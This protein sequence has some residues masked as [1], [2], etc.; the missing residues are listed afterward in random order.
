MRRAHSSAR[1]FHYHIM[2]KLKTIKGAIFDLDGTLLDSLGA[3]SEIDRKFFAKR[4]IPL[5]PDYSQA[6]KHLYL[7]EAAEY[8]V[9]R[10]GL[11]ESSDDIVAEW[12]AMTQEF[13]DREVTLKPFAKE[14]LQRLKERGVKTGIATSSSP[15]LF[16]PA[17]RRCGVA[18]F[19]SVTVTSDEV[20][21]GKNYPDI[22]LE[23]ARRLG[24]EKEH[25]AVFED[26]STAVKCAHDAGFYSVAVYD[27]LSAHETPFLETHSDLFI[28]SFAELP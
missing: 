19:F 24:L 2:E 23:T 6:V 17:L 3:W 21:R 1:R 16:T 8:T 5:P 4:N 20:G 15:E 26:L 10:F 11:R 22:Y 14:Y 7:K 12:K 28:R 25:C 18:E 13:Y 27:K 9:R